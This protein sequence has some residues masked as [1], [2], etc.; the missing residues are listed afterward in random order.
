MQKFAGL[1]TLATCHLAS[2]PAPTSRRDAP[3]RVM[4][5]ERGRALPATRVFNGAAHSSARH[6][7]FAP[8]SRARR[9]V[10]REL[11][12]SRITVGLI[13]SL[14]RPIAGARLRAAAIPALRAPGPDG[15]HSR[16]PCP[17]AL[18]VR[19]TIAPFLEESCRQD[20]RGRERGD[21]TFSQVEAIGSR[22][23]GDSPRPCRFR[24]GPDL[25]DH[26]TLQRSLGPL[27]RAFEHHTRPPSSRGAVEGSDR[28]DDAGG[29][30][31]PL[32][33]PDR[34]HQRRLVD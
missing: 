12:G 2:M 28:H 27:Q 4:D 19:S 13:T 24:F 14:P 26:D 10:T 30:A 7:A 1:P 23:L 31:L 15:R 17:L 21:N 25:S 9:R 32:I 22:P 33:E 11:C 20:T 5:V 16:A 8:G 18:A 34:K 6:D 29:N 3:G